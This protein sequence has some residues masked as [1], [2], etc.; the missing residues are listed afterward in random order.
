[1]PGSLFALS[2]LHISH[3]ANWQ[4][5]LNLHPEM[6]DD[7][8]IVAGDVGETFG[9]VETALQ[10]LRH[11]YARVIWAPGNHELCTLPH[12]PVRLRG[13]AR[14]QAL[15][16]MCRNNGVLTPE[17]EFAVRSGP[18]GPLTIVPLF[19]LYDYSWLAPGTT[20]KKE[21]MNY[22]YRTGV[23]CTDEMLLYSTP[24]ADRESWCDARLRESKR[25]LFALGHDVRTVLVSHWPLVR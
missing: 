21:S 13:E 8:L 6:A 9:D 14:Y 1:M 23:V 17:D 25:R 10:L 19:Q 16:Q 4:I 22:A 15:V 24:Y 12:D 18:T 11:R 20:T 3:E 2:D 7:W 5:V